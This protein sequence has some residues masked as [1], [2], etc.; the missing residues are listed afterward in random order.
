MFVVEVIDPVNGSQVAVYDRA[1]DA[2]R[3]FNALTTYNLPNRT[4]STWEM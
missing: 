2:N 1:E 3:M 4:V